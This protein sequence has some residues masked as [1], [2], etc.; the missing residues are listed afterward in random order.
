M[1]TTIRLD[2]NLL[3]EVKLLA[4]RSGRS[5]TA[6]IEDALREML[7]RRQ[8]AEVG[9]PV[10]IHDRAAHE[11]IMNTITENRVYYGGHF[12]KQM[13]ESKE[14]KSILY[15]PLNEVAEC[16]IAM[17]T[18]VWQ[19]WKKFGTSRSKALIRNL[20][21]PKVRKEVA[22]IILQIRDKEAEAI[23]IIEN[24]LEKWS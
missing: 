15:D 9:K 3:A 5:M 18:L 13:I 10:V 17:G 19:Y 12:L 2:D 23:G 11:D 21:K 14:V 8:S 16:Y 7:A 6:V 20:S 1:R 24:I 22:S 4:A